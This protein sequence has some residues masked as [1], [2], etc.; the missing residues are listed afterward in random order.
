MITPRNALQKS[1]FRTDIGVHLHLQEAKTQQKDQSQFSLEIHLE[2]PQH[3]RWEDREE[4]ICCPIPSR[5]RIT[6]DLDLLV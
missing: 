4:Q 5:V 3:R 2:C 6:N 1:V